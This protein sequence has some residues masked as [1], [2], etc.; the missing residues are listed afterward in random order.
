MPATK[1]ENPRPCFPAKTRR[2]GFQ[3]VSIFFWS[4]NEICPKMH[5]QNAVSR[6]ARDC[7][8]KEISEKRWG[9][10]A[11]LPRRPGRDVA[12]FSEIFFKK[13]YNPFRGKIVSLLTSAPTVF[14]SIPSGVVRA[15][16]ILQ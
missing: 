5:L 15:S 6:R 3:P 8:S 13:L 9:K 12:T 14:F 11:G 4:D 10:P 2:T 16:E 1:S 7:F